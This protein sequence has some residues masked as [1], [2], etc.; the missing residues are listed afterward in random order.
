[1]AKSPG[2]CIRCR[3][4]AKLTGYYDATTKMFCDH[5]RKAITEEADQ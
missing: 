4:W 5:A 1:M 2:I 3:L